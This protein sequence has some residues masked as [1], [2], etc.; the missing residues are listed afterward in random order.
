MP[1]MHE[2]LLLS[3][4]SFGQRSNA[5][6]WPILARQ[7]S[8]LDAVEAVARY[9]EADLTNRTVG[10]GG[11]PDASGRVSLDACIMLSPSK[12]GGVANMRRFPQP[13][14][15]A[16]RVMEATPH[17]L[18]TGAEAD[19][20]AAAQGFEAKELL[21]EESRAAWEK[22]RG[23]HLKGPTFK[24]IRNVEELGLSGANAGAVS[25]GAKVHN[26]AHD[27]IG[28]LGMDAR[29]Q[30]A[31]ACSTSG[32]PYKL[33]GRVG[34]SPIIGH[35]LYVHPEIGAAVATGYGEL[36]MGVCGAFLA[37]ESLKRGAT[38]L[39]A[40]VEVLQRI[41]DS[42]DLSDDDQVGII[43]LD[44][45]GQWNGAALRDGFSIAVRSPERD[46]LV[47]SL[48]VLL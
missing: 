19:D 12:R 42:Y 20:F 15:V 16:R 7:G 35:G 40:S 1:A 28:I 25:S 44:R 48:K 33:P 2:P 26:E 34:D 39:E 8:A 27:T 43:V 47:T 37:V 11:L 4:W 21:S 45:R 6:G 24:S 5:A 46:D 31:G 9:A 22:W 41:I 17:V 38:P 10:V 32:M 36:V 23:E 14:S 13:I 29:G 3:T 18:L 30:I